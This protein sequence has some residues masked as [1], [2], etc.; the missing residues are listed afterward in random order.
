MTHQQIY[1]VEVPL[2]GR[3]AVV[4]RPRSEAHLP[5]LKASGIDVLVS[6]LE[7]DEAADVGLA[8]EHAWCARAGMDFLHLPIADHGVPSEFRMIEDAMPQLASHLRAGRGVAAHCYAGLGRSPLLVASVLIHHG[9]P[10][11]DA[12]EAVSAARGYAVPEMETQHRWLQK[13]AM[14]RQSRPPTGSIV[15]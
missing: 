7:P 13:F 4:S 11:G 2:P 10:D 14:R 1:W 9:W 6:L 8:E 12:I 3:L 5:V 15:E